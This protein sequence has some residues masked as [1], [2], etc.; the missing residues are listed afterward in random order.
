M[1]S[2]PAFWCIVAVA[3]LLSLIPHRRGEWRKSGAASADDVYRVFNDKPRSEPRHGLTL[4]LFAGAVL[5][6]TFVFGGRL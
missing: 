2:E 4:W 5:V 6:I 1:F 3:A